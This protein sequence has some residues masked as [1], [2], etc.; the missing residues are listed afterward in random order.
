M[1]SIQQII[2]EARAALADR[3]A[4]QAAEA[5][6]LAKAKREENTEAWQPIIKAIKPFI[7]EELHGF[8]SFNAETEPEVWIPSEYAS[9]YARA[10]IEVK[11]PTPEGYTV[12]GYFF[13]SD[14]WGFFPGVLNEG[15]HGDYFTV[16]DGFWRKRER[17]VRDGDS[18]RMALARTIEM[19]ATPRP[20]R[21]A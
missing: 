3:R 6:S 1:R 13:S 11:L 14:C 5:E 7:P 10:P 15:E 8:I 9:G 21:I 2:D 18:F 4:S 16:E 19:Y 12:F 20:A 17:D